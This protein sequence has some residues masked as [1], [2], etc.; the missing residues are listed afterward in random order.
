MPSADRRLCFYKT[1]EALLN[2]CSRVILFALQGIAFFIRERK[3]D[4]PRCGSGEYKKTASL[5]NDNDTNAN[6]VSRIT[7]SKR[8]GEIPVETRQQAQ[9]M[10]LE[11]LGFR[12][13][14]RLLK[15]SHTAVYYWIKQAGKA[16]ELPVG[17][18]KVDVVEVDELHTYVNKKK[19]PMDLDSR[20]SFR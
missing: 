8:S 10:Y 9:D 14:G 13:I 7:R 18:E 16:L 11:G 1:L 19:L 6:S 17:E 2:R 15:V 12:A 20:E 5:K 4:C 3:M